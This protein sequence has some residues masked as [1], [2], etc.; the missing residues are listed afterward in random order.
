MRAAPIVALLIAT[1]L[2]GGMA[3]AAP[4]ACTTSSG[5]TTAV[6]V[7]LY[8][9]EGC[10]S[11]PPADK[12][13]SSLK[14]ENIVALALHVDYWNDL[15]WRDRFSNPQFSKR[16][17][18]IV[19]RSNGRAIFT[20]QISLDGRDF[21][22]WRNPE[23]FFRSVRA[24]SS[25]PAQAR[26]NL[27]ASQQ[28]ASSWLVAFEGQVT[29]RYGRAEA[30]LALYENGLESNVS[31]G[32]NKGVILRH[33]RVVRAWVGPMPIGSDGHITLQMTINLPPGIQFAKSGVAAIIEDKDSGEVLQALTLPFCAG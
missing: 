5:S 33:D 12:W 24:I 10:N 14:E 22:N 9:S 13:L 15:G 11:C 19:Q 20:P 32:E 21:R 8:T 16:Q 27:T 6:L 18:N 26:I 28:H 25:R 31:S 1:S 3:S 7:E 4:P 2:V 17:A 29:R 30:Y 23:L